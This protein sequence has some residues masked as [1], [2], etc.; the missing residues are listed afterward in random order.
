MTQCEMCGKIGQLVLADIE[1]VELSVCMVCAKHGSIRRPHAPA[2]RPAPKKEGPEL[3]VVPEFASLLRHAR[4]NKNM[5]QEEFSKF[6]NERESILPKWEAG[7][8][9]PSIETAQKLERKL[10]LKLVKMEETGTAKLEQSRKGDEL[11]LGDFIK[12][13]KRK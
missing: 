13:R 6:L 11:T 4:E 2:I 10:Q 1:G 3:M 7:I 12:V 5:S 9:V 8:L